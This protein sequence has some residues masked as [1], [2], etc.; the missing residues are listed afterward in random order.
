MPKNRTP[1]NAKLEREDVGLIR[2]LHNEGLSMREIAEKFEVGES[3]IADVIHC[4]TWR[5]VSCTT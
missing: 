2:A 1:G 3:T 5:S 4:R